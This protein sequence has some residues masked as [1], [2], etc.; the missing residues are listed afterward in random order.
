M[1][2]KWNMQNKYIIQNIQNKKKTKMS[3]YINELND[4]INLYQNPIS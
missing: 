3:K 4:V 1:T 2:I